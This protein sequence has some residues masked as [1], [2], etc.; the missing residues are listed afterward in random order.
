MKHVTDCFALLLRRSFSVYSFEFYSVI[1]I[2]C[3]W[4]FQ[5]RFMGQQRNKICPAFFA[6]ILCTPNFL[7]MENININIVSAH[8]FVCYKLGK[9]CY[10]ILPKK[11]VIQE[12][13][14]HSFRN[15]TYFLVL[16][17]TMCLCVLGDIWITFFKIRLFLIWLSHTTR[18]FCIFKKNTFT[19]L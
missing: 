10:Y 9:S 5:V 17:F 7:I 6:R 11:E 13:M 19:L 1:Q 2:C 8:I 16:L 3:Q 12:L 14:L 18:F 4:L 15:Q